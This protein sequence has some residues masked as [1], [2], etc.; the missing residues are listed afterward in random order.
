MST[1]SDGS[2]VQLSTTLKE[3]LFRP[4]CYCVTIHHQQIAVD[5]AHA[6]RILVGGN[7]VSTLPAIFHTCHIHDALSRK[8]ILSQ[9][10]GER[11]RDCCAEFE[12]ALKPNC[13]FVCHSS[14]LGTSKR[15]CEEERSSLA[16]AWRGTAELFEITQGCVIEATACHR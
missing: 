3:T 7:H 16:V 5:T 11:S 10:A 8:Y 9:S 2:E 1:I 14:S 6:M 12:K 13:L 15:G 4:F